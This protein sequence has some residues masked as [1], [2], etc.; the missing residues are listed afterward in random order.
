MSKSSDET[1]QL[2][3]LH[4][5]KILDTQ[6][7]ER[8]ARIVRM[9]KHLFGVPHASLNLLDGGRPSTARSSVFDKLEDRAPARGAAEARERSVRLI[10]DT[11]EEPAL[12]R[13]GLVVDGLEVRFYAGCPIY[14]PDGRRM[15]T[16]RLLDTMPRIL[17]AEDLYM[18]GELGQ[19]VEEGL[20]SLSMATCDDLTKLANRRGFER[21][22]AHILP[23]AK[24]LGMP[25]ALV[26][27]DLDDLKQINDTRG[28][29]AG[30]RS[31]AVFARHLLKNFRGS[32]VVA[33]LGGDEFCVLMSG[34]TEM[35]VQQSLQRLKA[36]LQGADGEAIRFSAGVA[37]FDRRR[38][39][40]VH[41]LLREAD[42]RMY[43]AKRRKHIRIA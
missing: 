6:P 2:Q 36:H 25:L 32:D 39:G 42:E 30:D 26:Q 22:A 13:E 29:E 37:V 9:A 15:G 38:H 33:R 20:S 16:L 4:A 40:A 24:R 12:A 8:F 41:D 14:A 5:L 17:S 43:D 35:D 10:V 18:L 19:L 31:L 28:H 3:V 23:M 7:E 27:I 11:L 34:A 1:R 21:I